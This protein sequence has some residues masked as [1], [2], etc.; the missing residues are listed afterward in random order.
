VS[1]NRPSPSLKAKVIWGVGL[2]AAVVLAAV[3][4]AGKRSSATDPLKGEPSKAVASAATAAEKKDFSDKRWRQRAEENLANQ[5]AASEARAAAANDTNAANQPGSGVGASGPGQRGA[6]G[7]LTDNVGRGSA[8]AVGRDGRVV[9]RDGATGPIV[10]A[11]LGSDGNAPSA[12]PT[13]TSTKP[14]STAKPSSTDPFA[15]SGGKSAVPVV[16]CGDGVLQAGELCEPAGTPKCGDDCTPVITDACYDCE[17]NSVC[18]ALASACSDYPKSSLDQSLCYDVEHCIQDT[19]CAAGDKTLTTCFCGELGMEACRSAPIAGDKAPH[20]DC[21]D[22]I[23][24]AM[25][26]GVSNSYVLTHYASMT[27]PAGAAIKR[28][29]CLKSNETCAP[30]CFHK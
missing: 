29:Q 24:N 30:V 3:L 21:A 12:S 28:F 25:G 26:L 2:S 9:L 11:R 16:G 22:V 4:I 5:L 27:V 17:V 15:A 20:G 1:S 8:D 23:R 6:N 14:S 13:S 7:A 18:V 19:G 10:N